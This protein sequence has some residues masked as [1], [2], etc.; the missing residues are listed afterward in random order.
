MDLLIY[1]ILFLL[2][3]GL[4]TSLVDGEGAIAGAVIGVI[5]VLLIG[6]LVGIRIYV[7]PTII[8]FYEEEKDLLGMEEQTFGD[9]KI[10]GTKYQIRCIVK[11]TQQYPG[12]IIM[13]T[14][15][16][17][18]LKGKCYENPAVEEIE[19]SL[20]IQLNTEKNNTP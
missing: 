13:G 5:A 4:V 14:T 6:V 16:K 7:N 10:V 20:R 9:V 11:A 19:K 12:M 18:S 17:H 8:T 2:L 3:I 15:L 1:I